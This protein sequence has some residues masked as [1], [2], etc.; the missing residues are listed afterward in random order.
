M[1]GAD[2]VAHLRGQG[3]RDLREVALAVVED[4]GTVSVLPLHRWLT[5]RV[6]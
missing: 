2:V 6:R 4:D 5:A 1:N 3:I